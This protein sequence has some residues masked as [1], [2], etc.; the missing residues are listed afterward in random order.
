MGAMTF[1]RDV[2]DTL[3]DLPDLLCWLQGPILFSAPHSIWLPG[4]FRPPHLCERGTGQ[5]AIGLA[6]ELHDS[7]FGASFMAW[8]SAAKPDPERLD[9]NY[10]PPHLYANS[11][12][13]CALHKWVLS[14]GALGAPL[15]HIDLHGKISDELHVDVGLNHLEIMWPSHEQRFITSLK[16]Q[17][18]KEL[19]AVLMAQQVLG[20]RANLITVQTE[21]KLDGFRPEWHTMSMQSAMLGVPSVQ[22]ELPPHLRDRLVCDAE[23]MRLFAN[24]ISK[25]FYETVV[26]W[27]FSARCTDPLQF[28]GSQG[29]VFV[30]LP[31]ACN[32]K[33]DEV[34]AVS[35][36][37]KVPLDDSTMALAISVAHANPDKNVDH[38]N[39]WADAG[40]WD[41]PFLLLNGMSAA[42]HTPISEEMAQDVEASYSMLELCET[43]A[44][45]VDD[46]G[47]RDEKCLGFWCENIL[48]SLGEWESRKSETEEQI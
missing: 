48:R 32:Q 12:W 18:A 30:G 47:L 35:A 6:R 40:N 37:S 36:C 10:L 42:S 29:D 39:D 41:D 3:S 14:A 20:P 21:P 13:H 46:C 34:S 4:I 16:C 33:E 26:P 9:P 7:D 38:I 22:L 28:L 44:S 43:L 27:W 45:S 19:E 24:C 25:V 5:I 23:L 11:Q 2:V 31:G 15:F 17:L 1:K 8:N